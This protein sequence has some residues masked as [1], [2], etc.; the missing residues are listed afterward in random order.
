MNK[1]TTIS[2]LLAL[3]VGAAAFTAGTQETTIPPT[4]RGWTENDVLSLSGTIRLTQGERPELIADGESYE[5]MYPYFMT[6]P[7]EVEDGEKIS[8]EGFLVPGP[9]WEWEDDEYHLMVTKAIIDGKEYDL[10]DSSIGFGYGYCR[11]GGFEDY[12]GPSRGRGPRDGGMYYDNRQS[13]GPASRGR[14]W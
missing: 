6:P 12:R 7:V 8:V 1:V 10:N 3:I 9:R 14:C 11:R 2:L 13:Y 4:P 5:L